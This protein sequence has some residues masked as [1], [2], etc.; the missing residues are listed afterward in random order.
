MSTVTEQHMEALA[1]ANQ[2]RL[3]RANERIRIRAIRNYDE[4]CAEL[5]KLL[6]DPPACM[7]SLRIEMALRWVYRM[8][9]AKI[10]ECLAEAQ[11]SPFKKVG[12]L[13]PRQRKVIAFWLT[14]STL[15]RRAA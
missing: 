1:L 10:V 8:Q 6:K 4:G 11:C 3:D 7:A 2:I 5:A 14:E 15:G 13:S 9:H 12:E